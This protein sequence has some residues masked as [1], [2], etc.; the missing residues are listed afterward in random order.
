VTTLSRSLALVL[1]VCILTGLLLSGVWR[2][3]AIYASSNIRIDGVG[4]D[5]SYPTCHALDYGGDLIESTTLWADSRDILAWYYA[6]GLDYV[7]LRLDFLDLAYGAE[8]SSYNS[9]GDA[10]N[11]YIL[12]G[13]V[14]APGYQAWVPDYV[15]YQ[16][17]GVYL[18]DYHWVI[19]IAIYDSENYR[20]YRYD[21]E[22]LLENTGLLIAFNSQW[23]LVEIAI[24]TSILLSWVDSNQSCLG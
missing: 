9:V 4:F 23:D 13:W 3:P 16:G 24:P 7:Y 20:V 12:L 18:P 5:W 8:V 11:I 15:K 17:Y 22:V 1:L 2:S 14:N 21:W 6:V 10:L 19:A